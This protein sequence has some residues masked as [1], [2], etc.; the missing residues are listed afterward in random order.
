MPYQHMCDMSVSGGAGRAGRRGRGAERHCGGPS[1]G[2]YRACG[3]CS[4]AQQEAARSSMKVEWWADVFQSI[5]SA[6]NRL[7]SSCCFKG[8]HRA[9]SD[10]VHQLKH[11]SALHAC[12]CLS[13][14]PCVLPPREVQPFQLLTTTSRPCVCSLLWYQHVCMV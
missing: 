10:G 13:L 11:C 5:G 7:C 8:P 2:G 14:F 4:A 9:H 3:C 6:T 12:M 1:S